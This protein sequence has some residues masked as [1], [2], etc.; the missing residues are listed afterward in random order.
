MQFK[1]YKNFITESVIYGIYNTITKKWYIGSCENFK[2]RMRRHYYYLRKNIHHSQKLQRSWNKYNEDVF[3]INILFYNKT[4]SIKELLNLEEEYIR[5]YDSFNNGYNMTDVCTNYK[6]FNLTQEQIDKAITSRKKEVIA[7]NKN[8]NDVIG[9]YNS[10]SEAAKA[11][12]EQSTN[13]SKCCK[14]GLNYVKN[15]V[16]V[17]KNEYDSNKDYRIEGH[18]KGVK[19]SKNHILKMQHNQ[20]CRVLYKYDLNYNLIATY[21]SRAEAE[22]QNGFKKEWLR[23]KLNCNINGFIYSEIKYEKDIV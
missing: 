12:N 11:F 6:K 21:F 14:H 18:G 4:L 17:Y 19:K 15:T 2:L 20:K 1:D 10:V 16:F 23:R 22:R 5:K 13:I 8:T 9:E 3:E 7:I